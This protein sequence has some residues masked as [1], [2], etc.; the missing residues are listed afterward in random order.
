MW[1]VVFTLKAARQTGLRLAQ[2]FRRYMFYPVAI[3]VKFCHWNSIFD[4]NWLFHSYYRK[5]LCHT[6]AP[7][8]NAKSGLTDVSLCEIF[9]RGSP[10]ERNKFLK[11]K[12]S[13]G[14]TAFN[15]YACVWLFQKKSLLRWT[16]LGSVE[17]WNFVLI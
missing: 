17:F 1:Y 7:L 5:V 13:I 16:F 15:T 2:I 14:R 9:D 3:V 8:L 11:K 12:W 6:L 4:F 10:V